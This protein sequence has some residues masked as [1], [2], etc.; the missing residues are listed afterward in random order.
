MKRCSKNAVRIA[1]Q[2]Q[3]DMVGKNIQK[4]TYWPRGVSKRRML[5]RLAFLAP[6]IIRDIWE[7]QLVGLR[8]PLVES[9]VPLVLFGNWR[10]RS[11]ALSQPS[12]GDSHS[13]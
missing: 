13:S 7:G 2:E 9:C 11:R 10:N 12:S 3:L 5:I 6:G 1:H 8:I 4:I